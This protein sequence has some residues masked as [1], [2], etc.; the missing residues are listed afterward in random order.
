MVTAYD[1]ILLIVGIFIG[2]A[3]FDPRNRIG[4]FS[5]LVITFPCYD[6]V[7]F[8]VDRLFRFA[9]VSIADPAQIIIFFLG[10]GIIWGAATRVIREIPAIFSQRRV[11]GGIWAGGL[12]CLSLL[13]MSDASQI[14]PKLLHETI[15]PAGA[16][17][18][19]APVPTTAINQIGGN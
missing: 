5:R 4:L 7:W 8:Q 9:S 6:V 15:A 13:I 3:V 1:F 17:S 2:R 14:I 12:I 18:P 19:A 11:F 16:S 10:V